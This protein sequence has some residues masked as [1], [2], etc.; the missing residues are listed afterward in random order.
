MWAFLVFVDNKTDLWVMALTMLWMLSGFIFLNY[1]RQQ[2]NKHNKNTIKYIIISGIF[3]ALAVMA[4]QTAFIDIVLFGLLL[5]SLWINSI[6]AIWLG[7]TV[8][9][10][11]GILQIANAIDLISPSVWVRVAIIWLLI[12]AWGFV[13]AY[14]QK[15]FKNLKN[16][17]INIWYWILGIVVSLLLFKWTHIAYYQ[18]KN[19]DF[20]IWNFAKSILLA[21]SWQN[22]D[23]QKEID[24]EYK[25][26]DINPE[27]CAIMT[28]DQEELEKDK[29]EAIV[30]NEDVWRYV[31]Y[32][33]KD[34]EKSNWLNLWYYM[35]KMI[36]PKDDACYWFN[37]NAKILCKNSDLVLSFNIPGLI[38]LLNDLDENSESYKVLEKSL[39]DA[40]AKW[41]VESINDYRDQALAIKQYYEDHSIKT[42]AG[43]ISIP[44]RYIIPLN[45]SFNRS[46]QN[47][48][49]Y[50]TDIGFVRLFTMVFIILGLIYWIL[51]KDKTLVSISSI[52]I[53]WR[54]IRRMIGWWILRYWLGLVIW[55][56]LA[57]II[58]IKE[59]IDDKS[60]QNNLNLLYLFL[61]LFTVWSVIQLFFNF[62]RISSQ[63]AGGPFARYKTNTWKAIEIDDSFQQKEVITSSYTRKDVFDLQFPHYNKFI[64]KTKDRADEDWVLIAGTYIQYFLHNQRNITMDGMLWMLREEMSDNNSCK[65]IHRLKQKNIKYLVIDQNIWTVWMWEWNET[66]FHR[67]FAKLNANA[68]KI[69][70]HWVISMLI[71]MS[72]EWYLNLINTNNLG[73]KYAIEVEDQLFKEY[74]GNDIDLILTRSKLA[75]A[76]YFADSNNYVNFVANVFAQRI[77][78]GKAIWDMADVFGKIIDENKVM[79]IA[80]ELLS[81]WQITQ[82]QLKLYTTNLTQDERLI[83]M[84]YINLVNLTKN[85]NNNFQEAIN[86]ILAQ[87]LWWSSQVMVFELIF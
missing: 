38:W 14:F 13:Y 74:F 9:W 76:R 40:E 7:I 67:F 66:L 5:V 35:L 21:D 71:K 4:K 18:I 57:S 1:D 80:F 81:S 72:Q 32:W 75:V 51:K 15:Q 61:I 85:N 59:L 16:I 11:T 20:S 25:T 37:K 52:T 41:Q 63:W 24:Q 54:A 83:L 68:D 46:L 22:I 27:T 55:T 56:I 43:I 62:I 23:L 8:V 36:F 17:S 39:Q 78:N 73:T 44:Y 6:I 48:S 26:K 3:F 58:Y 50:Y 60:K 30:W 10:I 70:S 86:S 82:E 31:G 45:I 47:L 42:Q 64:E 84:Q 29:K 33:R 19:H 12:T 77:W 65:T 79:N 87:S 34:F 69:D 53:L 49:S 28:F 2:K